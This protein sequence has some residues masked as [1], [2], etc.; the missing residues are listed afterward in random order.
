LSRVRVCQRTRFW[1][2]SFSTSGTSFMAT[3]TGPGCARMLAMPAENYAATLSWNLS[4]SSGR[5]PAI[6][7]WNARIFR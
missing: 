1:M 4:A 3:K 2:G 7:A 5:L 6:R